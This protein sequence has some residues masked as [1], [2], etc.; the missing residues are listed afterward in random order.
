MNWRL[1]GYGDWLSI[2]DDT[3]KDVMATAYFAYAA[4]LTAKTAQALGKAQNAVKYRQ[5]FDEIKTAYNKAYINNEG[6]IKGDTQCCYI[7]ALKMKLLSQEDISKAIKHLIRT[8][9]R[10]K[11][12]LSSGFVGVSYLLPMLTEHG[13]NDI[14]YKLLLNDTYPSWDYCIKNGATTIWERWNSYTLE[15]GFGDVGMNSFNHYSLGSIAEWMYRNMAGIIC[16][17]PGFKKIQIKPMIDN[18]LDFVSAEYFSIRGKIVSTWKKDK[19][20][21]LY[22]FVIPAGTI[23]RICIPDGNIMMKRGKIESYEIVDGFR[24]YQT[25]SGKYVFISVLNRV[26]S[27]TNLQ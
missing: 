20:N 2:E 8:I 23:A 15:N 17:E 1:V 7:L 19:A 10:K 16:F 25:G 13:Y 26:N 6:V 18:K 22:R 3:P 12:H 11:W 4:K 27:E 21:V 5:L 24:V 9:E 14:A